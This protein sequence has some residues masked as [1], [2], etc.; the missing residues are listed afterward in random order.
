[1]DYD[2]SSHVLICL[3]M[4]KW[5]LCGHFYSYVKPVKLYNIGPC[6]HEIAQVLFWLELPIQRRLCS[7]FVKS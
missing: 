6:C 4:N 7:I 1:M 5:A 2:F 3:S